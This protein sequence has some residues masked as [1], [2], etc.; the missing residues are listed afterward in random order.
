[1]QNIFNF[2]KELSANNNRD[3]FQAN[4]SQY[5]SAKDSYALFIE[6]LIAEIAKFDPTVMDLK[7]KDCIFRINRDVRFSNNKNPYKTNFGAAITPGGRKALLPT[8]YIHLE[9]NLSFVAGGLYQ[10]EADVL[11]KVRQEI[12]YNTEEFRSIVMEANFL[13]TFTGGLSGEK[14]KMAP[15]GYPKDHAEI[16]WLKH[17]SYIVQRKLPDDI[18]TGSNPETVVSGYFKVLYPLNQFLSR[19]IS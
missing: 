9:P 10:P 17:K 1:M 16:E 5:Q 11:N 12:D 3:W 13:K 8:Y 4:R 19:A 18:L 2:L 7:P 6:R 15:K 14:L